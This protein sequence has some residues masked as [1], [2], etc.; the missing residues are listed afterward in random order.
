M[1]RP[2]VDGVSRRCRPDFPAR[3]LPGYRRPRSAGGISCLGTA[4]TA[5]PP[6]PG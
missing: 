2:P 1:R 5:L 6:G 4:H 3:P